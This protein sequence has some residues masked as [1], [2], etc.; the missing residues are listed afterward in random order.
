MDQ[1]QIYS[2]PM[3]NTTETVSYYTRN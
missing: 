2:N 3:K 1:L